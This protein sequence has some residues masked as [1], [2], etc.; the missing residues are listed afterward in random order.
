VPELGEA[1]LGDKHRKHT[2]RFSD[3][4]LDLGEQRERAASYQRFFDVPSEAGV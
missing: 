4:G 1:G 3:T 2:Y